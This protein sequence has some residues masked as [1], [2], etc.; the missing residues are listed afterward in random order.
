MSYIEDY[1]LDSPSRKYSIVVL[2]L[3]DRNNREKMDI[4]HLQKV[5][6][7]FEYLRSTT[8]TEIIF[9]NFKKGAVSYELQENLETLQDSGLVE[10]EGSVYVLTEEGKE[11]AQKLSDSFDRKELE[12]M[13]F[14]KQQLNDITSDELMYF[15]YQLIPESVVNSTEFPRLEKKKDVIVPSLFLKGRINSTTAAK[16][17]GVSEKDFLASLCK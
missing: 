1:G 16:W 7:Y 5:I 17:L 12:K 15:M 4:M 13:T 11:I 10:K 9:S 6:R 2:S 3:K 8:T 14:A